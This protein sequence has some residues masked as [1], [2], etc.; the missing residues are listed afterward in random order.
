MRPRVI[1]VLVLTMLLATAAFGVGAFLEKGTAV[2]STPAT[3]QE[4]PGTAES[5]TENAPANSEMVLGVNP[6]SIPLIAAALIGSAALAGA[7]W[8]Y[9]RRRAVVW[10]AGVAMAAFAILDV[11][12]VLHRF[13]E[14]HPTLVAVAGI[15]TLLHAA[16]A[17]V[18][19][20]VVTTGPA[21]AQR[22]VA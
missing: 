13:S 17:V 2:A 6:E 14:Q 18:A 12:E 10:V 22:S 11:V 15:V 9:W 1:A 4:S 19:I 7:V 20:R 3:H 16:A 8:I 21:S 5:G